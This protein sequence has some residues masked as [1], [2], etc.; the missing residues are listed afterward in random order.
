MD[1]VFDYRDY[2]AFVRDQVAKRPNGGRG[3]FSRLAEVAQTHKATIS[4]I[5]RGDAHLSGEQAL[6]VA[7]FFELSSRDS[8]YFLLLV[9]FGAAGSSSLQD[10]YKRQ[11][12]REQSRNQDLSN[13]LVTSHKLTGEQKAI[14]YSN[15][16]YSAVRILSSI[17]GYSS[18][19]AISDRLGVATKLVEEVVEFLVGAG[20][21]ER[22][23]RGIFPGP[24]S[25]YL[26]AKSPL[27][28]RHHGNWRL[29][30]MQRHPQLEAYELAYTAPVSLSAEDARAIREI[31][32]KAVERIDKLVEP[33]DCEKLFCLNI[34]WFEVK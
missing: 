22:N 19:K 32:A 16:I 2:K 7:E 15:W 30:A 9:N 10:M 12:E 11:I 21:C 1:G 6:R 24:N 8:E 29:K 23:S 14:F 13:R 26:D 25:T 18:T 4:Q 27:I 33:S 31:L 34:D 5:F 17:K 28:S 20:L 3:T